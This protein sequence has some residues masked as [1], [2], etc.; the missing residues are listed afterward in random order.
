EQLY[1]LTQIFAIYSDVKFDVFI[2]DSTLSHQVTVIAKNYPNVYLSGYWWY[3]MYPEVMKSYLRL[4]LQMLPYNKIG[5]FFSDAYVIEWVYGKALLAKKQIAYVLA[6]M[7]A[8]GYID[9]DLAIEIAHALLHENA[10]KLYN[11]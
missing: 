5:G 8:E 6:E 4:R 7:I 11:V 1:I 2:A 3:S 10:T 9:N